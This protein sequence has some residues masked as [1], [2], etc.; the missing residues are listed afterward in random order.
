MTVRLK[1]SLTVISYYRV[2]LHNPKDFSDPPTFNPRWFL[3]CRA[4]GRYS[5]NTDVRDPR[6]AVFGFGC[7]ICPGQYLADD[8]LFVIIL[9]TMIRETVSV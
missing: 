1:R 5:H 2:I 8:A 9:I 7:R 6:T 4:N 3:I